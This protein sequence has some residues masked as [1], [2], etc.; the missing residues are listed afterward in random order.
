[1]I[2]RCNTLKAFDR[3]IIAE[4][5]IIREA[6]MDAYGINLD[7]YFSVLSF[8]LYGITPKNIS[9]YVENFPT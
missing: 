8:P 2:G 1:M 3:N 4:L 6:S 7:C 5:K 9:T